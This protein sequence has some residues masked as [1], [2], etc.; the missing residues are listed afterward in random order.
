ML[1]EA[2]DCNNVHKVLLGVTTGVNV[3]VDVGIVGKLNL[4]NLRIFL[5]RDD[6]H[7]RYVR[8]GQLVA[9]QPFL[10]LSILQPVWR[11][12]GSIHFGVLQESGTQLVFLERRLWQDS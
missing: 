1:D 10:A 7:L 6:V 3:H 5:G 2:E 4:V 11:L 8:D 12:E 9:Q